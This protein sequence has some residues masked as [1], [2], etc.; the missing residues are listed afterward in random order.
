M[1]HRGAPGRA[2]RHLVGAAILAASALAHDP[3]L[4]PGFE[5][6]PVPGKFDTATNLVFA[7]DATLFVV[8]K[9]GVVRVIRPDGTLQTANFIDLMDEVNNNYD[10]GLLSLALHPDFLPDGGPTSWVYLVYT[11]SPVFGQDLDFDTDDKYS[12][13]RLTRWRAVTVGTDVKAD[14]ASRQVLLGHQELDGT[15]PDGIASLHISH[16]N[17]R[18]VFGADGTLLLA[19]GEGAHWDF[20]DLGGADLPGFDDFLHPVTGL[21]GPM[22]KEQDTGS[23]RSQQ[24]RSL[25]GKL[26]RLDPETGLGLPSNP[27][28]DGDP[29]SLRSRVWATGLRNPYSMLR[30][31]GTGAADPALAQPGALLVGD[32]GQGR[33]EELDLCTGGENFQWPCREGSQAFPPFDSFVP[34][35]AEAPHCGA[36]PGAVATPQLAWHHSDPAQSAAG[37][38]HF[39]ADGQP[40]GGFQGQCVI[41]GAVAGGGNFPPPWEGRLF[42]ADFGSHWLK[43]VDLAPGGQVLALHDFG[44]DV[45]AIVDIARHPLTG[46]F[47]LSLIDESKLV[48]LRYAAD[49]TPQAEAAATPSE[50]PAPLSVQFSSAG[51]HDPEGQPL[52]YSW[53]F[54][55]GSPPSTLPDPVHVYAMGSWTATLTVTDPAGQPGTDAVDIVA[56]SVPIAMKLTSPLQGA[57]FLP[58]AT[59]HLAAD[60]EPADGVSYA[61]SVDLHHDNHVHPAVFTSSEP[62]ADFPVNGAHGEGLVYYRVNLEVSHP[63][64]SVA[65]AHAY[66]HDQFDERDLSGTSPPFAHVQDFVPPWSQGTGNIDLEVLRDGVRPAVGSQVAQTQWDSYHAGA[67]GQDDWV[68]LELGEPQSDVLR[69]ISLEFQEGLHGAQGGWWQ[70]LDVEVRDEGVWTPVQNLVISPPYPFAAA[71]QGLPFETYS[72]RFDAAAGDAIRL[73]GQPGGT[74]DFISCAELRA[75]ALV[76]PS[77]P[78]FSDLQG[79]GTPVAKVLTLTPPGPTGSGSKDIETIRNGTLP[80][81]GSQSLMAQYDTKHNGDQGN[82]DWIGYTFAQPRTVTRLVF[83]EGRHFPDGGAF[84]AAPKVQVQ[85]TAHGPWQDVASSIDPVYGGLDPEGYETYV[86]DFAPVLA[87]GVRLDGVPAG[88]RRYISVGELKA[89]GPALP[90]GCGFTTFGDDLG[91]SNTLE[92]AGPSPAA[93]GLPLLVTCKGA[94]PGSLGYLGISL[95]PVALPLYHGTLLVH[96]QGLIFFALGYDAKGSFALPSVLPNEPALAGV[97]VHMQ[98]FAFGQPAPWPVR[99]SN[100]LSLTLCVW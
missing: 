41:V 9:F 5:L 2:L 40:A 29:A 58:P 42:V 26:L 61:W 23:L 75:R 54:G 56:G 93:L 24:L 48:R 76:A 20:P 35:A 16:S 44:E 82:E 68:G 17:G 38:P 87:S 47:W 64:G 65:S 72:L 33:W 6:V 21:H 14:L 69:W 46:D 80:P 59:I 11:V 1:T 51:S 7:P 10:R 34:S 31:P 85:T 50:G 100:G 83:Q 89:Q 74:Q 3:V 57:S 62:V 25:S 53:D 36:M 73:R 39:D 88:N 95:Q 52:Q 96:P 98:A 37:V 4:P 27:F 15:V 66:V 49:F 92:L 43:A 45:G 30:V 19:T 86:L 12:F 18:L 55:D 81:V 91:G 84:A 70:T 79:E 90:P 8:Q 71:P 78:Q 99:L 97:S 77:P 22:P 63:S 60:V 94:E 28:F 67:Q 13:S 32:V